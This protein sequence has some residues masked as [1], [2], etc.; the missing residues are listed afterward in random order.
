MRKQP[1]ILIV[2][3]EASSRL[4]FERILEEGGYEVVTAGGYDEAIVR[5]DE[6]EFD[7]IFADIILG[8]Q[9]G[10]DILRWT[11][12]RKLSIP[13]IMITG[14]PSASSAHESFELG[15]FAHVSKPISQERLLWLV[16]AVL[17]V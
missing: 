16:K 15:A 11:R 9:S 5:I 8:G 17:H 7:L 6:T 4:S 12:E 10:L 14:Y 2:D 3:D 1:R 13:V